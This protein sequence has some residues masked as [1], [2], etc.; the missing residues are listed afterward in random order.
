MSKSQYAVPFGLSV[1]ASFSILVLSKLID[2]E[3]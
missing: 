1:D 3:R 2:K